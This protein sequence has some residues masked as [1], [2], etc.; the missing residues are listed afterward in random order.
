MNSIKIRSQVGEDGVLTL[1]LPVATANLEVD[2]VVVFQ[3]VAPSEIS[4]TLEER[5]WLP[6]FFERTSGSLVDDPTFF[7]HPQ[8]EYEAR[9]TWSN[10]SVSEH[11]AVQDAP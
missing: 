7:R 6:G 2:V 1:H 9:D 8:G 11:T 3:T 4:T 5:G 10:D